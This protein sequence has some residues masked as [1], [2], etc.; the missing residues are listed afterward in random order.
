MFS[1]EEQQLAN[2]TA[3]YGIVGSLYVLESIRHSKGPKAQYG[4]RWKRL[5]K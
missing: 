4:P 5:K 2:K 1:S 3:L